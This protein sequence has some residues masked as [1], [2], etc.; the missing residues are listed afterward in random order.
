MTL[1]EE[2]ISFSRG[3]INSP[4]QRTED[5]KSKIREV[6]KKLTGQKLKGCRTCYIEALFKIINQ[7]KM[8]QYELK[9]GVLLQTIGHPEKTCTS[10]TITDEL[11]QW[12]LAQC[13]GKII[14]FSRAPV[15]VVIPP[16]PPARKPF[17]SQLDKK[18]IAGP[19]RSNIVAPTKI[20]APVI[21]K[22]PIIIKPPIIIKAKEPSVEEIATELIATVIPKK[23]KTKK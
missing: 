16:S 21:I 6:Y 3:Y 13:P 17:L 4:A 1:I 2:V 20:I 5:R 22:A 7:N 11:A 12:H 9:R 19:V 23:G 10:Q 18:R 14:F 8:G 15:G